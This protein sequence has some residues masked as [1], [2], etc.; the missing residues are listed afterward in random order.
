MES[1][2]VVTDASGNVSV[3]H[4]PFEGVS[5]GGYAVINA[6]DLNE[7]IELVKASP[8]KMPNTGME[9]RR[10][11]DLDELPIPDEHKAKAKALR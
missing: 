4:P 3:Q 1:A 11:V 2:R 9:I 10:V 5:L 7:V 6:A 8:A